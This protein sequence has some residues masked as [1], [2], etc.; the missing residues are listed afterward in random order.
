MTWFWSILTREQCPALAVITL[1]SLTPRRQ[2]LSVSSVGKKHLTIKC[3]LANSKNRISI[4][5]IKIYKIL[6]NSHYLSRLVR[7]GAC[8]MM[9]VKQTQVYRISFKLTNQNNSI[10]LFWYHDADRQMSVNR[11][12]SFT[13]PPLHSYEMDLRVQYK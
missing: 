5:I 4:G 13:N 1:M 11:L 7:L 3:S 2:L 6:L 9:V 8:T 10:R 12:W